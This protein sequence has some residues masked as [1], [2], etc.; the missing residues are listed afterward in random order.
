MASDQV[1]IDEL[2]DVQQDVSQEILK[3]ISNYKKDSAERT[4]QA[5]YHKIKAKTLNE[6]WSIIQGNDETK[7]TGELPENHEYFTFF[8]DI[9][10]TVQK[11]RRLQSLRTDSVSSQA[12]TPRIQRLR[13]DS[14]S[15]QP[16]NPK[17]PRYADG[18][19]Q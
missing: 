17:S 8:N 14:V 19:R 6:K 13:T 18:K 16:W 7:K 2:L 1:T 11:Y 9:R 12:W 3:L 5:G 10:S 15:N 4:S